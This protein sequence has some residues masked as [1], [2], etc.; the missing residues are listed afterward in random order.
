V[1]DDVAANGE[2]RKYRLVVLAASA[3]GLAALTRVLG[4]L[5][6]D[7]P[8][9]VAVVQHLDPR[10]ISMLPDILSRRTRLCVHEARD[11]DAMVNA[12]VYVAP[13]GAHMTVASDNEILLSN[14]EPVH[15]VRPSAD[16]LFESAARSCG[17]I[18][19]VIL[20]GAGN[21]G[22]AGA[23]AVRATGGIVIAQDQAT[24]AFFG[25]PQAAIDS[26]MVDYILPLDAIG[27]T[28]VDLTTAN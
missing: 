24:S 4:Q 28:L 26:G 14:A 6:G 23:A 13:P 5:P 12:H 3:G 19:A 27:G 10:H 18:I 25:M 16:V 22:T 8:L 9:P 17:P 1:Q 20:T 21:D 7:F 2:K 15:F 11:H